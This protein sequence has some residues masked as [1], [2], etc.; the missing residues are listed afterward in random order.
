[1]EYF[2]ELFGIAFGCP[3]EDRNINCPLIGID[4]LTLKQRK[5]FIDN[6]SEVEKEALIQHHH[7]CIRKNSIQ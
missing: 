4:D 2:I 6:L 7:E 3:R 5:E 1:M